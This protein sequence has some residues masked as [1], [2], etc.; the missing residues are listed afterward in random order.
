M[1]SPFPNEKRLSGLYLDTGLWEV[2]NNCW[3]G[4]CV[5]GEGREVSVLGSRDPFSED[6]WGGLGTTQLQTPSLSTQV[7][8]TA[9]N[10]TEAQ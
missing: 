2:R 6:V 3:P 9:T 7:S 4:V 5:L 1:Q 10:N 8:A